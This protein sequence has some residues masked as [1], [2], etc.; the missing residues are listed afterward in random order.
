MGTYTAQPSPTPTGTSSNTGSYSPQ[1]APAP[2]YTDWGTL[3]N[4]AW[5]TGYN[6]ANSSSNPYSGKSGGGYDIGQAYTLGQQKY[7]SDNQSKTTT[8][9]NSGQVGFNQNTTQPSVDQNQVNMEE[10]IRKQQESIRSQISG[11]YDS[12]FSSLDEMLNSSLPTQFGLQNQIIETNKKSNLGDLDTQ[13]AMG[14]TDLQAESD[15]NQLNQVRTLKDVS[16]NMRNLMNAGNTYL[17]SRGA[18]DSSAV[19][20]YGYALTKLGSKQRGDVMS[21]T[22]EIENEISGRKFKLGTIYNNEVNKLNFEAQAK[23]LEVQQW[24]YGEQDRIRN[25]KSQGQFEKSRDL[26]SLSTQILNQATQKLQNY[27][28][29]IA[30]KRASL[31][32]WAMNN[33]RTTAEL[34]AN[35]TK[36]SQYQA[37]NPTYSPINGSMNFSDGQAFNASQLRGGV[38]TSDDEDLFN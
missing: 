26:A 3:W 12:Y 19:N 34:V 35:L 6:Q 2:S 21:Q 33:S 13:K 36:V 38:G 22:R 24:F 30:T 7:L 27:Q 23:A 4:Q 18:G 20:Q 17:G 10:E 14:L 31:E 37:Q 11:G 15:K 8:P 32:T 25:M 16:S 1:P 5:N 28:N 9:T 29:E